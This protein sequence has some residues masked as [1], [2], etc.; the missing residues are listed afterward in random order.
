[1]LDAAFR[2][3]AAR[4]LDRQSDD[5]VARRLSEVGESS[6]VMRKDVM[7]CARM[8]FAAGLLDEAETL[9]GA[10]ARIFPRDPPGRVGLAQVAAR[11][12]NWTEALNRWDEVLAAFA[13]RRDAFWLASRASIL[14]ELDRADEAKEVF[15]ELAA[16]PGSALQGLQ[17]RAQMATRRRDWPNALTYWDEAIANFGDH[18][19]APAWRT[20]RANVLSKLGRGDEAEA[21]LREVMNEQPGS[22]NTFSSLL[23]LLQ[24][25]GRSKDALDELARSEFRD[26]RVPSLAAMKINMLV[27]TKQI[28]AARVEFER[29]L[30]D[31][32]DPAMLTAL[33]AFVA[34][35]FDGWRRTNAWITLREKLDAFIGA[36]EGPLTVAV[37]TLRLRLDLA[38]RDHDRF[39][40]TFDRIGGGVHLGPHDRKL[41]AVARVLKQQPFP[42]WTRPKVFGIGMP[43]TGTTT[44]ASALQILGFEIVDF[45]NT[46]TME[47]WC[48]E[49]LH[50]FDAFTDSP[51]SIGFEKYY[52]LFPNSKFIYTTRPIDDWQESMLGQW[53]RHY[54]LADYA[55]TRA[56]FD[57]PDRFHYGVQFRDINHLLFT[58]YETL[59][60]GNRVFDARVRRFFEDKPPER[61][62]E[63]DLFSGHGWSELCRF[64]GVPIPA[65]PFPW[66]N[67]DPT[68]SDD[69]D[70]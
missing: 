70:D 49:D 66:Q 36:D 20:S 65:E 14:V 37:E 7:D 26:A 56:E 44:L 15:D 41:R 6:P 17:G 35:I 54:A 23:H 27:R 9:F 18:A 1:M 31:A 53:R 63:F 45:R 50:L 4:V 22:L 5:E 57:R 61:F 51:V 19:N 38:L 47:L 25:T 42:D 8:L 46:L 52:H 11:H 34:T 62:L 68:E 2:E 43:K 29:A 10:M 55:E 32:G 21:A 60:E 64:F 48:E 12:Q 58:N 16:D 3:V 28:V 33:F 24:S 69:S 30:A 13:P 67:R 59:P 40:S 39:L